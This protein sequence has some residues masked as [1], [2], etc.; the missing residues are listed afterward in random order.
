MKLI[1]YEERCKSCGYCVRACTK[2]AL[3]FVS[4]LNRSGYQYVV[5]DD[6]ICNQCGVCYMVCPDGVFELIELEEGVAVR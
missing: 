2:N 1:T 3:S 4:N 6:V 5:V